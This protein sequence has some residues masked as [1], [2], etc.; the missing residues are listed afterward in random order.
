MQHA[1]S[2]NPWQRQVGAAAESAQGSDVTRDN[3]GAS[4]RP[5]QRVSNFKLQVEDLLEL[6][7]DSTDGRGIAGRSARSGD[8]A[9]CAV[10][11]HTVC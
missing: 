10:D 8:S 4:E 3:L 6:S 7:H 1:A 11:C 2:N 9:W 5:V